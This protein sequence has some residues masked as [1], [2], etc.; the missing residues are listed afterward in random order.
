MSGQ[1]IENPRKIPVQA[2]ARQTVETLLDAAVQVLERDGE[3]GFTTNR[4]AEAAG[5]SIGTLYQYFPNKAA[6]VAALAMR[7]RERIAALLEQAIAREEPGDLAAVVGVVVRTCLGVMGGR[8]RAHRILMLQIM[9][10][11]LAPGLMRGADALSAAVVGAIVEHG[12]TAVRPMSEAAAFV[13]SRA[14]LGTIRAAVLMESELL[15]G[16]AFEAEL[17]RL[18]LRFV[19]PEEAAG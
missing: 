4:V 13:L 11:N 18:V 6:I 17:V 19:T 12:G 2:R 16:A 15:G 10:L 8:R 9:R 7:E 14:I 3:A 1:I 5:F